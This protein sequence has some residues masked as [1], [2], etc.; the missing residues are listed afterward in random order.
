MKRKA[1]IFIPPAAAVVSFLICLSIYNAMGAG[2]VKLAYR[3]QESNEMIVVSERY[4]ASVIDLSSGSYSFVNRARRTAKE[5]YATELD[6]FVLTHYHAS[7]P[8]TLDV[9]MEKIMLRRICMP[10]PV[11]ANEWRIAKEIAEVAQKHGCEV[12]IYESGETLILLSDTRVRIDRI[13]DREGAVA[14]FIANEE[15]A[16][17]YIGESVRGSEGAKR[18]ESAADRVI[19]GSHGGS[20]GEPKKDEDFILQ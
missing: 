9:L 15:D 11:G 6:D 2:E 20:S 14:V 18:Y 7:H 1:L 5:N 3:A 12:L 17:A 13:P 4:S 8:E 19:F 10:T 16:L